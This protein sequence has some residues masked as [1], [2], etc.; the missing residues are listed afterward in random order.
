MNKLV[1]QHI[2]GKFEIISSKD[3]NWKTVKKDKKFLALTMDR[4]SAF[5]VIYE[6]INKTGKIGFLKREHF[7][8]VHHS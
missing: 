8:K 2:E 6:D 1:L 7:K 4:T 3:S 5:Q